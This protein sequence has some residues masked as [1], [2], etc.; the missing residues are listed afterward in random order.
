MC[1]TVRMKPDTN[2]SVSFTSDDLALIN[3]YLGTPDGVSA[4]RRL[5]RGD[6]LPGL[7]KLRGAPMSLKDHVQFHAMYA[8]EYAADTLFMCGRQV[9]KCGRLFTK[10]SSYAMRHPNGCR[11]ESADALTAA[12]GSDA[13]STSI[14]T[15][16]AVMHPGKKRLLHIKTRLGNELFVSPEHR[17]MQYGGAYVDAGSLKVGSLLCHAKRC[18]RFG[19]TT[20]DVKRIRC[21]AYLIGD[22]HCG[23]ATVKTDPVELTAACPAII[24]DVKSLATVDITSIS[25]YANSAHALHIRF[26]RRSDIFRWLE[27]DGLIG[28]HAWD[29]FVP[30]WVFDLDKAGT[31]SFLEALWATDGTVMLSAAGRPIIE[32][33]TTSRLLAGDVRALLSKYGILTHLRVKGTGY[34]ATDGARVACRACYVVRVE[35]RDSQRAFLR[36]FNVPGKPA[37]ELPANVSGQDARSN[38]DTFPL[39]CNELVRELFSDVAGRRGA[40]MRTH[41]MRLKLKH[42][43]SRF[44]LESYLRRADEL[45]LSGHPAYGRIRDLLDGDIVYDTVVSVEDAGEH[46]TFDLTVAGTHNYVL[47]NIVVHNSLNLSRIEVLDCLSNPELQLLYV[48]PL[49]S[50]AQRYS[51][52]YLNEAIKSCELATIAQMKALEGLWSDSKI[53]TSVGHQSFANG[54]GIQL[55]YAKT[56]PDRARGIFADAIDFDEVQDQLTD[57]IPII[58]QSTKSSKWGIRRF[59]GTAKTAD[60][61]IEGLWRSSSQCE[62]CMKCPHCPAWN[63]PNEEG[64]VLDMIQADGL[65]CVA[66]GGLLDVRR[67]EWVPAVPRKMKSFRGYHIP[68]VVLPFHAENPDNWGKI[69]KDVL[70]LPVPV[71]MQEILGISCSQGQRI[72]TREIIERQ[73]DLPTMATLQKNL[74]RYAFIVGGLDWGGAEQVSFTVHVIIGVC[75]DGSLEVLWARR[76]QGFDPDTM[77]AEI[78]KTHRFYGCRICAADY[79]LGFDKNVMLET[80]YGLPIVQ[81][82]LCRQNALLNYSPALGHPRWM[83]DKTT[84]LDILFMSIKY[85]KIRFPPQSEFAIY[86]DD[87]LSPYEEVNDTGEF[88]HRRYVRDP[89]R[90]DDF[91][92]A[93]CFGAMLAMKLSHSS[94]MD[95]VPRNAGAPATGKPEYA[96]LDPAEILRALSS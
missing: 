88:A 69:V 31:T 24:R 86:T 78:A 90:P 35:G 36:T 45:G 77:L 2:P 42:P 17:V 83:V 85:G 3:E 76:Y 10:T 60:N 14:R 51:T 18:Y 46:D 66:C 61:T 68:Q 94:I 57:N 62:W 58:S 44:K 27:A 1:Y 74:G 39:A 26:S 59:T 8:D 92:M 93:L 6:M 25:P 16:T 22:G 84:A 12:I 87:L 56:S 75:H 34:R 63:I 79:G 7:F 96:P 28:K 48:A 37:F 19:S 13:C 41:G 70:S 89:S 23:S 81:I 95:M 47:D 38:R 82:Q 80:R 30:D 32:Y 54:S 43:P 67:G 73:S 49:Q 33:N 71:V 64:R 65:H 40:G 72:I 20:G 15:V 91:A 29:K 9:G 21:T 53:L 52:L 4:C 5:R 50:Q 55:T 11:A